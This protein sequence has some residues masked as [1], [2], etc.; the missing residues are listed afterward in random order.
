[1]TVGISQLCRTC[2]DKTKQIRA[3]A[4]SQA[5]SAPRAI[6]MAAGPPTKFEYGHGCRQARDHEKND[7]K[8]VHDQRKS[9]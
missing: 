2:L 6:T 3:A 8:E 1:M 7:N 9:L 4:S 5:E